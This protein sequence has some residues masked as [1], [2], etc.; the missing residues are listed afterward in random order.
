MIMGERMLF[1]FLQTNMCEE[2]SFEFWPSIYIGSPTLIWV[3]ACVFPTIET[4][5]KF[6]YKGWKICLK[7]HYQADTGLKGWYSFKSYQSSRV[8]VIRLADMGI[9]GWCCFKS[10]QSSR[11]SPSYQVDMG[12]RLLVL[13]QV[14]SI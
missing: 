9:R 3:K 8:L 1:I 13:L 4:S 10:Y 7:V 2:K 6:W 14:V 5:I 11:A 12:M